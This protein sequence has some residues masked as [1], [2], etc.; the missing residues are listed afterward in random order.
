MPSACHGVA[1]SDASVRWTIQRRDKSF[2]IRCLPGLCYDRDETWTGDRHCTLYRCE[3]EEE[4]EEEDPSRSS[5][6]VG[7][8]FALSATSYVVLSCYLPLDRPVSHSVSELISQSLILYVE[9]PAADHRVTYHS[10][11]ISCRIQ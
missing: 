2:E 10:T 1:R 7:V 5:I 11:I 9:K 6:L 8:S 4:E 3:E